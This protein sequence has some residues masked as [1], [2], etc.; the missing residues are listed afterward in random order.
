LALARQTMREN[1]GD[2]SVGESAR[3]A[4]FIVRL[5]AREDAVADDGASGG[6][7]EAPVQKVT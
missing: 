3:G 7:I 4:R 5:P 1:G 2:L 6:D